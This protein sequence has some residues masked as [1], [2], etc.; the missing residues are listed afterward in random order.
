MSTSRWVAGV[1]G[2]FYATAALLGAILAPAPLNDANPA[3]VVLAFGVDW[4]LTIVHAALGV[5][6]LLASIAPSE[7]VRRGFG[8]ALTIA[9]IGMVSFG[10]PA[11]INQGPDALFN[12]RWG[13]VVIALS[14]F[15]AT[16]YLLYGYRLRDR[17]I[18]QART[19]SGR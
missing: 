15:A 17:A 2:V 6:G 8:A 16:I 1:V 14:T 11:A 18:P 12:L 5:G 3:N 9:S 19:T 13:N 7:I 10:I 4:L